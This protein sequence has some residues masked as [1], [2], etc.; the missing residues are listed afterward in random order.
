[1]GEAVERALD[2]PP[3]RGLQPASASDVARL[4]RDG[5]RRGMSARGSG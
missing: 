2:T 1:L 4:R 5:P 3:E